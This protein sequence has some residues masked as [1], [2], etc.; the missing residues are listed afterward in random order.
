MGGRQNGWK[1]VK[2]ASMVVPRS[3]SQNFHSIVCV[4]KPASC[5]GH[6]K[7]GG[8]QM[9]PSWSQKPVTH[10]RKQSAAYTKGSVH[11]GSACK[12]HIELL[13]SN[14]YSCWS[15]FFQ[16]VCHCELS[17]LEFSKDSQKF[18]TLLWVGELELIIW[19][20]WSI[21]EWVSCRRR[22]IIE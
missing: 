4:K 19:L 12:I 21:C 16:G 7:G 10:Q 11:T 20:C 5:G 15:P 3:L 13:F 18:S 14:H 8:T 2:F 22:E 9:W 1:I 6:E 17:S